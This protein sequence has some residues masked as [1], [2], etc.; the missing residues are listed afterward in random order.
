MLRIAIFFTL[1]FLWS[2]ISV[3]T[4]IYNNHHLTDII[5]LF[6]LVFS[7]FQSFLSYQILYQS[8]NSI[9]KSIWILSSFYR[10][11]EEISTFFTILSLYTFISFQCH[12]LTNTA[13]KMGLH[14]SC[15]FFNVVF[16]PFFVFY[17]NSSERVQKWYNMWT[18]T[19]CLGRICLIKVSRS[20]LLSSEKWAWGWFLKKRIKIKA[21]FLVWDS[22]LK[23][24]LAHFTYKH[25]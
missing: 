19:F 18:Y 3:S 1:K 12:F 5:L 6:F 11:S 21:Q 4:A 20:L 17:F 16:K 23:S 9:R 2:N 13:T 22:C 10:P 24:N 14:S 8:F 15:R 25:F 7:F